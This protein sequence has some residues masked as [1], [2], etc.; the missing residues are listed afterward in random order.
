VPYK[1]EEHTV[2]LSFE[3][4]KTEI[5]SRL[6]KGTDISAPQEAVLYG[7]WANVTYESLKTTYDYDSE[8]LRGVA[9]QLWLTL[10]HAFKQKVTKASLLVLIEKE[11][12]GK[13]SA[14]H[15]SK[16][17]YGV[18]VKTDSFWGRKNEIDYVIESV[19]TQ[20]CIIISGSRG[21]GK[22]SL[23]S[24]IFSILANQDVFNLQEWIF[25]ELQE[26]E[27]DAEQ[28]FRV[29][30]KDRPVSAT[31]GLINLLRFSR[32]LIVIDGA[33]SWLKENSEIAKDFIKNV[34]ETNHNSCLLLTVSEPF[35][36][37]QT[38]ENRGRLILNLKLNGLSQEE[39]KHLFEEKGIVGSVEQ[40][41]ESYRGIPALLL[42]ACETINY[43]GG[44]IDSFIENKTLFSTDA[45]KQ[46]LNQ[47]FLRD[48]SSI[49]EKEKSIL[50]FIFN[51]SK[52]SQILLESLLDKIQDELGYSKPYV[53][54][55]IK[56]LERKSLI[57]VNR[58]SKKPLILLHAEVRGYIAEDPM[59]IFMVYKSGETL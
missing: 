39:S 20:R 11:A 3:E 28:I 10:S 52:D 35:E 15:E 56:E 25:S 7:A 46:R 17:V 18:P 44:D 19:K 47:L 37:G 53:L 9:S 12:L 38:L 59:S 43:I 48:D 22:T 23:A 6:P 14:H 34:V 21:V 42:Y 13:D 8:Y 54:S 30:E 49:A 4:F 29:L 27:N 31:K 26:L 1:K 57:S 55:A 5:K 24:K 33:D 40:I 2:S 32:S 51:H 16:K 36:F 41:I 58:S 45:S 50:Y